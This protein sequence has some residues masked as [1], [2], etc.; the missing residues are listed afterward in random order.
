MAD[1]ISPALTGGEER[2]RR[3]GARDERE[4]KRMSDKH[5]QRSRACRVTL[6]A[7]VAALVVLAFSGSAA[8]GSYGDA[9]GDSGAAPD[10]TG[11][12]V[13][14]ADGQLTFT[15]QV[16]TLFLSAPAQVQLFID[17]DAAPVPGR[18]RWLTATAAS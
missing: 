15:L 2:S 11:A 9:T 13:V 17:S 3:P 18:L 7:A 1:G 4:W 8:A 12:I 14:N 10:I 6:V 16:P 5:V